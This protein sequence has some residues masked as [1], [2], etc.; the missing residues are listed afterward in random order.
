MVELD[1]V[2]EQTGVK[3]IQAMVELMKVQEQVADQI[4]DSE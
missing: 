3:V 2:Q 1:K 4:L